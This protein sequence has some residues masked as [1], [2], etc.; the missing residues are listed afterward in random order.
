MTTDSASYFLA[1]VRAA[2]KD[3]VFVAAGLVEV[4]GHDDGA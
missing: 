3:E 4:A 1:L 2:G